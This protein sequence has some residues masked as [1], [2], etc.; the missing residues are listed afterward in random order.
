MGWQQ[1][2]RTEWQRL[3]SGWPRSGLTQDEYCA[4]QGISVGSLQRWRNIFAQEVTSQAGEATPVSEFMPV[5][6][7]GEASAMSRADLTLVLTDGLRVEVG[8]RC[9]VETLKRVLGVLQE[10][11]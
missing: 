3:V 10:R 11:T 1:R 9:S 6:L 2:S 4:R 5:T 7:V 8:E